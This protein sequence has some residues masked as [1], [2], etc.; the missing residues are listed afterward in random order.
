MASD[1]ADISP[2]GVLRKRRSFKKV[3]SPK[4]NES[5]KK[6]DV[7]RKRASPPRRCKVDMNVP[8]ETSDFHENIKF[9]VVPAIPVA[10][11]KPIEVR[12]L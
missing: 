2:T 11:T 12:C 4:S 1:D 8:E 5:D 10:P 7:I 6:E 9:R 3:I